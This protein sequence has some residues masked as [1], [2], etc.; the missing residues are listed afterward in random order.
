MKLIKSTVS[1]GDLDAH[2]ADGILAVLI[3]PLDGRSDEEVIVELKRVGAHHVAQLAP[4][5]ISA[6]VRAGGL[7]ALRNIAHVHPK[8]RK[9]PSRAGIVPRSLK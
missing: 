7:K 6:R 9:K 3:E 2:P 1:E 4:G 5:F 8:A